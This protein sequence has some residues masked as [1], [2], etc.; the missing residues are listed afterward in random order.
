MKK[1][2]IPITILAAGGLAAYLVSKPKK[3]PEPGREEPIEPTP[4]PST[5]LYPLKYGSRGAE[6]KMLQSALGVTADGIWGTNTDNA[7]RKKTGKSQITD[8]AD[9]NKTINQ[10]KGV[11]NSGDNNAGRI[12]LAQDFLQR[13]KAMPTTRLV[14]MLDTQAGQYR[15]EPVTAGVRETYLNKKK[16]F[17]KGQIFADWAAVKMFPDGFLLIRIGKEYYALSPYAIKLQ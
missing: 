13:A 1:M 4:A 17:S 3:Q 8:A 16:L 15:L 10:L 2:W 6:V 11:T 7:L 14:I 5:G 9:L 12:K